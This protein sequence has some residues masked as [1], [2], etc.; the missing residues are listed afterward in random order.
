MTAMNAQG[1]KNTLA[2][3]AVACA[4]LG[5]TGAQ[6]QG[7]DDCLYGDIRL[8]AGNF[9]PLGW[10]PA[11]GRLLQISEYEVL[12]FIIGTTYGGDGQTNFALPNLSGRIPVGTGQ[13]QGMFQTVQQGMPFGVEV[14]QLQSQHMPAHNHAMAVAA[15]ATTAV[16]TAGAAL[17]PV[18]NAGAYAV[19]A[20]NTILAPSTVG[21]AGG[22]QPFELGPPALGLHYI[23][24][25]H[26][27]FPSP[28]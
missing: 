8:F 24:C 26:G 4:A 12:F 13:G 17:A 25:A 20:P 19:A 18:H 10:L 3:A 1:F 27:V 14:V 28:A 9:A 2:A 16:P 21:V 22:S 6:A 7:V 11:N 5:G 23:I 15:G